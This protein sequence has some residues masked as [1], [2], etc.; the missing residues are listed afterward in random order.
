MKKN[1][2]KY[3][4]KLIET[5]KRVSTDK[6]FI[7]NAVSAAGQNESDAQRVIDY[8]ESENPTEGEVT[9]FALEMYYGSSS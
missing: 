2:P 1:I 9:V 5:L 8:I 6:Y 4:Q 7:L 3:K